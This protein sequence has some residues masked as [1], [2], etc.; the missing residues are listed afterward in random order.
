MRAPA[1]ADTPSESPLA[2]SPTP[3]IRSLRTGVSGLISHQ[4]RMDVVGNNIANVNT[5]GYK[6]SRVAFGDVLG[7]QMPAAEPSYVGSGARVMSVDQVWTQGNF[8]T[9]G[10]PTDLALGGDGFFV[11]EGQ[12]GPALTRAGNFRFDKDGY[13]STTTGARVQGWSFGPDGLLRQGALEDIRLDPAATAP[14]RKTTTATIGGNLS[15]DL[16]AAD[17]A[18]QTTLSTSIYDA[19]GRPH[20]VLMTVQKTATNTWEATARFEGS[21]TPIGTG[22]VTFK[23]DGTLDTPTSLALSGTF[24]DS[25]AETF[26]V[27]VGLG[28]VTQYAGSTTARVT[29]QNGYTA[30]SLVGYEFDPTGALV[31]G[32]SN[33][34]RQAVGQLAIGAVPNATGLEPT[35]DNLFLTTSASGDLSFGRAGNEVQTA[36]VS[37]ALEMSNVDLA[38]EFTDM[39]VTQRGYQASARVITTSDELL[40][41]VVQLK[42]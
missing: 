3:M 10:S 9:T 19:Q 37:G 13:L 25:A 1:P 40:Q 27:D 6:R 14:P 20:T 39:I 26:T 2:P 12:Y 17:P 7:Q 38:M 21:D 34:T 11:V 23:E 33:G 31:L 16:T 41:E 35:G 28:G 29:G 32:F 24:P 15:A 5:V 30:G 42:R 36:V 4:Q 18:S 8:E 22:T